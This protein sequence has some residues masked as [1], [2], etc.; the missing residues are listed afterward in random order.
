MLNIFG[1]LA[2]V[3]LL[4]F[5]GFALL[6]W[7]DEAWMERRKRIEAELDR[8]QEQLRGTIF[9][10]AEA[11]ADDRLAADK[12]KREMARAAYVASGTLPKKSGGMA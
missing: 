10:L 8:K 2:L 7:I 1:T 11:L 3:A 12:T 5:A 6:A 9:R 4:I